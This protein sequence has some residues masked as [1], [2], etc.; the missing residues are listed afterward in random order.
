MKIEK[1]H[2]I[3]LAIWGINTSD[4][5]ISLEKDI[6]SMTHKILNIPYKYIRSYRKV[7]NWKT[8]ID[9][10]ILE[11][12]RKMQITYFDKCKY[13]P[14]E[15]FKLHY[16]SILKQA[17][18]KPKEL[19]TYSAWTEQILSSINEIIDIKEEII[20]KIKDIL[21]WEFDLAELSVQENPLYLKMFIKNDIWKILK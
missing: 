20:Y 8:I 6:H 13:L 15:V 16:N 4:N 2:W 7:L 9:E 14:E 18:R 19:I 17:N 1:H 21:Q 10:T 3:P 12:E 11:A 5:I